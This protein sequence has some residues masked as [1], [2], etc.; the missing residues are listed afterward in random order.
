IGPKVRMRDD[1]AAPVAIVFASRAIATLP[2]AKRSPII[3]D[4]TT[5]ASSNPVPIASA[6]RRRDKVNE[7][8]F[9]LSLSHLDAVTSQLQT[10]TAVVAI[11]ATSRV[12]LRMVHE[13]YR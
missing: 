10:N 1:S 8:F 4:P 7:C 2:P 9:T 6:T 12:Y 11:P 5:A 3:P 13:L